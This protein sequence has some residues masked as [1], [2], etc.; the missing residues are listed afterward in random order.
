MLS[1][2]IKGGPDACTR[3]LQAIELARPATSL[4]GPETLV[5]HPASSTHH[6]LDPE[7]LSA[8]AAADGLLRISVGLE[9]PADLI[10][11]FERAL[12]KSRS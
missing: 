4:G 3:F 11:D 12:T 6:G 9:N 5:C 1:V 10:T 7:S 2:E 8:S